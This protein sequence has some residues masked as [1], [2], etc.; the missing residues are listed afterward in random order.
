MKPILLIIF[1]IWCSYGMS[2]SLSVSEIDSL[3]IG[4]KK[5]V[6]E[7]YVLSEKAK[8]I[9][10]SLQSKNY[11]HIENNDSLVKKLNDDFF[12][13]V[14]DKH[15]FIQYKPAVAENLLNK[16]DIY[17]EQNRKEKRDQYGF[18]NPKILTGNI[19]YFKLKYFADAS[20]AKKFVTKFVQRL[21]KTSALIIDARENLGGSG[22]MLQL[23][24][25]LFLVGTENDILKINYK[26][27]RVV[28]MKSTLIDSSKKYLK[29]PIYILCSNQTF[30]AGEAFVLIM[31]NRGRAILVGDTTAG[32]GNVA[33]PH[34]INNQFVLTVPVGIIVDPLT[35]K[36]WEHD[37]VI[38]NINVDPS[39]A[40]D[41]ALKLALE[42]LNLK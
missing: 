2:Q 3:I 10:E 26:S 34:A 6:N 11:Y 7:N 32:A 19:G 17:K 4:I 9:S 22:S 13:I 41:K 30:S 36:G 37:G 38:P 28:T 29:K 25:G 42:A 39:L 33:G 35:N 24:T 27:G 8:L 23:L 16:K 40:L 1:S 20:H 5:T 21:N 14:N 12:R 15:L 31:K 18:E